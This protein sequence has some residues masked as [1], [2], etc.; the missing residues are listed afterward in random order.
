[1]VPLL[2]LWLPILVTTVGVFVASS[3]IWMALPIHKKD[4]LPIG[5]REPEF[6]SLISSANLPPGVH[7]YPWCDHATVKSDPTSLDRYKKG[8]WGT[9]TVMP[10][11]ANMGK[12]LGLW[13]ANI[14]VLSFVIAYLAA[15]SL[16][17]GAG[18]VQVA[19]FVGTVA[20]L[21]YGGSSVC[22]CIWKGMPWSRLPGSVF[23][24]AVYATVNATAFALLWPAAITG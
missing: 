3:I 7:M 19:R 22:D 23:D 21:A 1:M 15:H 17:A 2:S 8:P 11:P 16:P 10:G 24:A 12:S 20:M 9:I 18:G 13:A 14:A 6:L 5:P 4:Y